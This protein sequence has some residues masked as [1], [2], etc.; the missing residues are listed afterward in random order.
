[1]KD[2]F[3]TPID[4]DAMPEVDI[5]VPGLYLNEQI[6]QEFQ[7]LYEGDKL[8]GLLCFYYLDAKDDTLFDVRIFTTFDGLTAYTEANVDT[9]TYAVFADFTYDFTEQLSLSV[10]GRYTWD[11]RTAGILR[12]NYLGG[13]SPTLGGAGIPFGAPATDFE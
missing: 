13:G 7:L 4:F 8:K 11:E 6:S 5:D 9:E 10:G 12:P 1:R 3:A 2:Y